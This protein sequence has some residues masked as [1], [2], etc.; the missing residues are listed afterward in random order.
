[1]RHTSL[2]LLALPLLGLPLAGAPAAASAPAPVQEGRA[3]WRSAFEKAMA[4][5]ATS[6]MERLVKKNEDEA[7]E[8]VI[9]TAQG[10]AIAPS[11]QLEQR[12]TAL[13]TAWRGALKTGFAD[14]VY[15][16]YSLLDSI[17]REQRGKAKKRYDDAQD[18][19]RKNQER[20]DAATYG[21][22]WGEFE[23]IAGVF[24]EFGDH[25]FASQ[26][27]L[28]AYVCV[29]QN[30][31]G[32]DADLYK[33]C[34]AL[35]E[36][37][38]ARE[39]IDLKD[40]RYKESR[41]A[42]ESLKAQGYEGDPGAAGEEGGG[43][44]ASGPSKEGEA[45][46][47][48]LR[49]EMLESVEQFQRPSYVNDELHVI[50]NRVFLT[51]KGNKTRFA[52]L[53]DLSPEVI[54][55]GSAEV[56]VDTDGDGAGDLAWPM[57]GKI[58]PLQFEIGQGEERR[59]WGV[60][61][62]I[63]TQQDMYQG[64]QMN[65]M[66]TDD[67][68]SLYISPGASMVG[69][70]NGE[71]IRIIDE[72]M[73]GIYGSYPTS[74]GHDGLTPG[75]LHP[76]MD[77]IVIGKGRQ[78]VPFSEYQQVGG[79][80]YRLEVLA[81]G[82]SLKAYPVE[83]ETGSLALKYKGGKPTWLVVRGSGKY[84]NSYFDLTQKGVALPPGKWSLFCGELRKGKKIQ[85]MKTLIL[86]GPETPS[87]SVAVGETE[88]V[89]LGA[90]F[91][92]DFVFEEEGKNLTVTGN[93]IVVTGVAGERYERPWNCVARPSASYRKKGDKKGSKA[94]EL[95]TVGTQEEVV[96]SGWAV[97]WF[98]KDLEIVKKG[99]SD[100]SEVQLTEK[101]NKLFGKIESTWKD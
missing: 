34:R 84:E 22:L 14:N 2:L 18:R 30:A 49:F 60:L 74:W 20:K 7:I 21:V 88:S 72:N 100:D 43:P 68:A 85:T 37:A 38:A 51:T 64:I 35:R 44:P 59:P 101:K 19:W 97:A 90:P 66:P 46:Q 40:R 78:A 99:G 5:G 16:Y 62:T 13:R 52:S 12:M 15:E 26:A 17:Q 73:D 81:G 11:E 77:S 23:G 1:M 71:P 10:F 95:G 48:E 29:D 67:Q 89:E 80:W 75:Q 31:R 69:E 94:E 9:E 4:V 65:M 87:W 56:L 28:M 76:E 36:A 50:W 39:R 57:R 8:W 47:V 27:W 41:A 86:P 45:V 33:A 3:E 79:T 42:Y 91:G 83:L 70:L 32:D 24:E 55:T 96:A 25:Y 63:G 93:T 82:K 54:R 92:F 98:P 61:T 6:E 58:D 53:G